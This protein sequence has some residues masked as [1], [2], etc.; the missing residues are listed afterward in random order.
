MRLRRCRL[1]LGVFLTLGMVLTV[2]NAALLQEHE[3]EQG[4]E[5]VEHEHG[6][7][8]S[9]E[10][11]VTKGTISGEVIDIVCFTRHDSR[12]SDHAKCALYCAEQ[13]I[14]LGI[15]DEE[16]GD[17]YLPLPEG[18]SDPNKVLIDYIAKVV[19]ATGTVYERGGLKQ[20][21]IE[22]IEVAK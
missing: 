5:A 15:L 18:H 19:T 10:V 9:K 20:I 14:P 8:A 12:G 21:E 16:S 4:K 13:G 6:K 7:E 2:P 1:V 17:I 3:H 11:K 22:E